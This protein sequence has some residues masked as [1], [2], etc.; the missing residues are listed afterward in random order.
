KTYD[1]KVNVVD[2]KD[3][4]IYFT[5]TFSDVGIMDPVTFNLPTYTGYKFDAITT[6]STEFVEVNNGVVEFLPDDEDAYEININYKQ[7][8]KVKLVYAISRNEQFTQV[9][10]EERDVSLGDKYNLQLPN[11][12]EG[13]DLRNIYLDGTMYDVSEIEN[14]SYTV[15]STYTTA[16]LVYVPTTKYTVSLE[17]NIAGAGDVFG[18]GEYISDVAIRIG[19]SA[20]EGYEFVKWTKTSGPDV[21]LKANQNDEAGSLNFTSVAEPT[22]M[23]PEAEVTFCAEFKAVGGNVGG[24]GGGGSTSGGKDTDKEDEVTGE[25]ITKPVP[26]T[27]PLVPTQDDVDALVNDAYYQNYREYIPY[28]EGYPNGLIQPASHI[29]RA[30]VVSV[31]YN[32]FG[33]GYVSDEASLDKYND[34]QGQNWYGKQI[35]FAADFGIVGGYSDG[36]FRPNDSITRAELAT[37]IAKLIKKDAATTDQ[38]NLYDIEGHWAEESIQKLIAV[39]V[40][41]GYEDKTFMPSNVT[42][43][44]EFVTF[45]NRLIG[46]DLSFD[47]KQTYPDLPKSHWAY[48]NM[49]NAA[50]GGIAP[51]S[52]I[53]TTQK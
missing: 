38:V 9:F 19:A 40:V 8:A 31:I 3:G 44:A 33:N 28:M 12:Y 50:N 5:N 25:D 45:T 2:K 42:T 52:G 39:G 16:Y 11:D 24:G 35:A 41:S 6:E 29:T 14:G 36:T 37:I 49:M 26:P 10:E 46:R 23:M 30:E 18:E 53:E 20:R 17:T 1:L 13:Y 15:S 43:R 48:E 22:F 7:D 4:H 47:E 51:T 27:K 32:L 21:T 34:V